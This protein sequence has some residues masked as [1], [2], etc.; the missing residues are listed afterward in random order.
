MPLQISAEISQALLSQFTL[1]E[2]FVWKKFQTG[3]RKWRHGRRVKG[4][5]LILW[6]FELSISKKPIFAW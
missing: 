1:L 2:H 4:G 3:I 5:V 6:R